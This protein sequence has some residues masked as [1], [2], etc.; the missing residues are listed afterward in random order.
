MGLIVVCECGVSQE[1]CVRPSEDKE[2]KLRLG[3]VIV[4]E[5]GQDDLIAKLV[6]WATGSRLTHCFVVTG[7]D[8]MVEA[9]IPRVRA[10]PLVARLAE[11][12]KE[13]RA[14]Y[15]MDYPGL[16]ER[17]RCLL[18]QRAHAYV[19]RWYDMGQV[20]LYGIARR[21]RKDGAGT[22]TCSRLVTALFKEALGIQLFDVA[23]LDPSITNLSDLAKGECTPDDL[24]KSKL[25]ITGLIASTRITR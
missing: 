3:M 19:G 4:C 14:Y 25:V 17:D 2:L 23:K 15:L 21:F 1:H 20:L 11:L 5:G 22:L 24:L 6:R 16:T 7:A 10:Q 12:L 18:T 8:E 9:H 13:N